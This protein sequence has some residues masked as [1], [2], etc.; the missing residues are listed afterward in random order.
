VVRTITVT[1]AA[2]NDPNT[3]VDSNTSDEP[4]ASSG[5][6]GCIAPVQGLQLILLMPM[7]GLLWLGLGVGR[8]KYPPAL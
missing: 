2:N 6:G 1:A 5:G 8:R 4:G 3:Q 7:F